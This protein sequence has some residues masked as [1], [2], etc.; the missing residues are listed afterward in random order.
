MTLQRRVGFTEP[1]QLSVENLPPG[2]TASESAI[3]SSTGITQGYI[4][5]TAAPDA[6]LTHRVVQVVGSVTTAAG[7]KYYRAA[8]PVEVYRIQNNDQTVQRKNVIVSVTETAPFILSTML[9]EGE[10]SEISMES[11]EVVVTPDGPIA[12]D[13]CLILVQQKTPSNPD[14]DNQQL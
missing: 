13:V 1:I 8:T 5:L 2:I 6:E 7:N 9:G 10:D 4:T 14:S 3:L 11:L 12:S